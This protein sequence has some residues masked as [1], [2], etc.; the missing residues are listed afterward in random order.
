MNAVADE[1]ATAAPRRIIGLDKAALEHKL[2]DWGNWIEEHS[3]YEGHNRTD[4]I[5]AAL[6]G[7][8]GGQGGHRILCPD[9]PHRLWSIHQRIQRLPQHE[10]DAVQVWYIPTRHTE[11]PIEYV[12][13]PIETP[14][15]HEGIVGIR[16]AAHARGGS[17]VGPVEGFCTEERAIDFSMKLKRDVERAL[18]RPWTTGEKAQRL[19]I[20]EDALYQR[21]HRA[22][23]RLLGV[24]PLFVGIDCQSE[25]K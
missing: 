15:H 24:L 3:D 17:R 14:L 19:G 18:G 22:R 21:L 4:P 8:G 9:P 7:V 23:M 2:N 6:D 20:R 5:A 25:V 11:Q 10:Q 12:V 13:Y 1:F 16:Y